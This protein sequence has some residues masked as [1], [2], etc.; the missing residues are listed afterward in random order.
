MILRDSTARVRYVATINLRNCSITRAK[1]RGDVEG[2]SIVWDMGFR[3]L[4]VQLD[5]IAAISILLQGNSGHQHA[6]LV[7][8]F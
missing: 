2:M 3:R 4:E 5:S 8:R 7:A 1:I 6:S